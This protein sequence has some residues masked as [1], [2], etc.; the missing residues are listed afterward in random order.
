L[1]GLRDAKVRSPSTALAV[2]FD[3]WCG[4]GRQKKNSD[5]Q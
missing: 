2:G 1:K 4:V 3:I 5:R